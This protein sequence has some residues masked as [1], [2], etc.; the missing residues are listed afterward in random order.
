VMTAGLDVIRRPGP[1]QTR[2]RGE[3]PGYRRAA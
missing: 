1:N 2:A 3:R